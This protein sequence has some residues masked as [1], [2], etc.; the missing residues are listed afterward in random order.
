[1]L[2][3]LGKGSFGQCLKCFD[4]KNKEYVA[5]KI[6]RNQEKFQ[7]QA[8]VEIKILLHLA[9]H[10]PEDTSNIIKIKE[11]FV[12]RSHICIVFELLSINL[13]EFIKSTD[14]CGVSMGLI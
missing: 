1:M 2:E 14:F 9:E 4:H 5:L 10:D 11:Y 3:F 13:Y 6:I 8:S 12:F 7:Y